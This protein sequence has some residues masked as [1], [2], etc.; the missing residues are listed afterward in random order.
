MTMSTSPSDLD[1]LKTNLKST[2]MTGDF[3]LIAKS[4]ESGAADFVDRLQLRPG[5]KVLDVACG[6]GN[7]SIPAAKSGALVTGVDIATNLLEQART[8]AQAEGIIATFDEGDAEQLPYQDSS[9]DAVMTMFG[10]MFAPR[11]ELASAEMLRVCRSGSTIAMANW[12]PAG[13]VGQMFAIVSG[14]VP[15]PNMPSPIKWGEED[16][17]RERLGNQANLQLTKRLI[18]FNYPF[19]PE[20]VV[21][22]FRTYFGPT[23]NAFAAL[24]TDT[25][26]QTSLRNALVR[27]WADNNQRSDGTT[28]VESEY[29]EVLATKN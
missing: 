28:F 19:P 25:D 16:S 18:S 14:Y 17:V 2:W 13:F 15:P 4:Y 11:P 24:D 12:T 6:T 10:A 26:K 9:F 3:G 29:L 8:R 21:E 1:R 23:H 20:E 7:L 5:T 22:H 27:L